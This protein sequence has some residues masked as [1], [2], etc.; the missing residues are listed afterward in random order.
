MIARYGANLRKALEVV[1]WLA[2][3]EPGIDFH[4]ILNLLFFA[5][6]YHLNQYGR[7]IVGGSYYAGAYG[8]ICMPV[9]DVLKGDP[10]AVQMIERNGRIPFTVQERYC[11]VAER[12]ADQRVLSASDMEA[13]SHAFERYAHLSFEALTDLSHEDKAYLSAEGGEMRYE[14]LLEET[15]DREERAR[16]LAEISRRAA[17]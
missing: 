12:D 16:D 10:L 2:Y 14:D 6:K 11:V 15:A 17:L 4:K 1:L 3:R 5:D 8:P 13:L 7:P 9:Y